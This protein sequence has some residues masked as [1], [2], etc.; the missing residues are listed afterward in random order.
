[1]PAPIRAVRSRSQEDGA[2]FRAPLE[3]DFKGVRVAWWRGL[4]GIPFEPEIRRVVDAQPEGVRGSRLHRRGGRAGLR[5]RRRG[6]PDC[7][8]TPSNHAQYAPLVRER[9]EWVK[10]T[11]K[12]E[13]AE[14]ERQTG[15]DVGR[16]LARQAQMYDA[17]PR[18]SSS[19]TSTS[20]CR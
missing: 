6:V 20:S 17:E 16:A 7:C 14:A 13:V 4:G 18:S 2:R 15:A 10:D 11:I 1:M 3:R 12:F 9:P 8:A 5:R 19:A